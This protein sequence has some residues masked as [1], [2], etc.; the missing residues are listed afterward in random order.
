MPLKYTLWNDIFRTWFLIIEICWIFMWHMIISWAINNLIDRCMICKMDGYDRWSVWFIS[1]ARWHLLEYR[2]KY[3]KRI[4]V[5]CILSVSLLFRKWTLKGFS[6]L[7]ITFYARWWKEMVWACR[8]Q[9]RIVNKENFSK[10]I[11]MS[12]LVCLML[13]ARFHCISYLFIYINNLSKYF[14]INYAKE[15]IHWGISVI[16]IYT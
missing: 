1:F 2:H 14:G 10:S 5:I 12:L 16:Y 11:R 15:T 7:W 8:I 9:M 6:R 4:H 13:I 3:E